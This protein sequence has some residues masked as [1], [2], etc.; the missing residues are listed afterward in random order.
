MR[1]YVKPAALADV[2]DDY[3]IESNAQ[4]QNTTNN[5]EIHIN[6]SS[7]VIQNPISESHD[8]NMSSGIRRLRTDP[9]QPTNS[10]DSGQYSL[11]SSPYRHARDPSTISDIGADYMKVSYL[12]WYLYLTIK[13]TITL[14]IWN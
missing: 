8:E 1:V 7:C 12:L 6:A 3:T 10:T 14:K 13:I 4:Y 5:K 2:Y 9:L 11:L